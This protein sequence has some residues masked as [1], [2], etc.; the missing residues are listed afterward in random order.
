MKTIHIDALGKPCPLP[1]IE[2]K[3]AIQ[4]LPAEGGDI[5]VLVDNEVAIKNI[6]KMANGN[7]YTV[8]SKTEGDGFA[9]TVTVTPQ[10]TAE[11]PK[12]G[13]VICFSRN[14]MGEGDDTLGKNLM[15]TYIYSLTEITT[16]PE[17]LFFYNGGAFL[18]NKDS[19]VLEDLKTLEAKGTQISTCG[20]CLDFYEIKD[21]L[22]IGD[23]TNMFTITEVM[24][25]AEKTII[26]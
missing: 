16:P 3:K 5:I 24:N 6:T 17:Q 2:T 15:K 13:A 19:D 22:A 8:D 18:T 25:Q 10:A 7:G 26:L 14:V 21:Q 20:A 4:K 9:V 11:K 12:T 23:I 1:V